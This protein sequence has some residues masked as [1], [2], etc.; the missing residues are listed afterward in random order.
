M[1]LAPTRPERRGWPTPRARHQR[2]SG[3][4]IR[5]L[6]RAV[7]VGHV[8]RRASAADAG[9]AAAGQRHGQHDAGALHV[10]RAA[11]PAGLGRVG[12]GELVHDRQPL[13]PGDRRCLSQRVPQVGC[14][15]GAGGHDRHDGRQPGAD[16]RIPDQRLRR[17]PARGEGV[18]KTL[19][20]AY[21]D[22]CIARFAKALGQ[23][24]RRRPLRQARGKLAERVRRRSGF[25][26]G[27][28]GGGRLGHPVQSQRHCHRF[29]YRGQR[30]AITASCPT[31]CRV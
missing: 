27:K 17:Q 20:Y 18:S 8:P 6:L 25:M 21:D 4:G 12:Q 22:A 29:L 30:L 15:G 11:G 13:D 7:A 31:T 1:F 5:L 19:E 3:R 23:R 10:L 9:A 28:T 2:A 16:A 14:R 24:R 26:R